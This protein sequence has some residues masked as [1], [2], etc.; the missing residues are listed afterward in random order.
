MKKVLLSLL[1]LAPIGTISCGPISA[2]ITYWIVKGGC[3]GTIV[4]TTVSTGG[5]TLPAVPA[6][7]AA[8]QIAA[9]SAAAAVA[10]IPFLP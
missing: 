1:L 7:I 6:T 2:A 5:T 10:A 8:T 4:T 3:W 9:V